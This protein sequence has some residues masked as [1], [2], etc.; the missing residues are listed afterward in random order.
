VFY[1]FENL[2]A[3]SLDESPKTLHPAPQNS[4]KK[5]GNS[6]IL[7]ESKKSNRIFCCF[8]RK[9]KIMEKKIC[10]VTTKCNAE[11]AE[12]MWARRE[13]LA[14]GNLLEARSILLRQTSRKMAAEGRGGIGDPTGRAAEKLADLA[15]RIEA[16][17]CALELFDAPT[18][19]ALLRW[20]AGETPPKESR[21]S[22]ERQRL[23]L[24]WH[25]AKDS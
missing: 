11:I 19:T 22:L 12:Y 21:R 9:I 24:Y 1:L 7:D 10:H 16:I 6:I 20:A 13:F 3:K 23:K 8:T 18:R 4:A 17:E 14:Y 5:C 25:L 2:D 15:T